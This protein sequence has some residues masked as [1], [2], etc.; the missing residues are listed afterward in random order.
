[1]YKAHPYSQQHNDVG[2]AYKT[3][4]DLLSG[5]RFDH[6]EYNRL[7]LPSGVR[8]GVFKGEDGNN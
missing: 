3:M 6:E 5:Q 7:E 4:S 2:I 8:G 1:M